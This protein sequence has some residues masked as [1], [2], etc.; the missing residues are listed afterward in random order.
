MSLSLS[1]SLF[2]FTSHLCNHLTGLFVR[3]TASRLV[4]T[5]LAVPLELAF[6][7]VIRTGDLLDSSLGTL[8]HPGQGS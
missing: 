4:N 1:L 7:L 8:R 6:L 3:V 2:L 5:W